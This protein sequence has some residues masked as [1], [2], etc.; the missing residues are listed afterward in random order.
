MATNSALFKESDE[1]LSAASVYEPDGPG[2]GFHGVINLTR[3]Q[4]FA[5]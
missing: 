2:K 4:G 3:V 5:A 1:A